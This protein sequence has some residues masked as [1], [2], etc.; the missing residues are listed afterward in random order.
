MVEIDDAPP[1]LFF[2]SF[3]VLPTG[4]C[5]GLLHPLYVLG[6]FLQLTCSDRDELFGRDAKVLRRSEEGRLDDVKRQQ[7]VNTVSHKVGRISR[8][9]SDG[10]SLSP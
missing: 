5:D 1:M 9:F 8:Y 7:W 4:S 6:T 3:E 10:N 2:E